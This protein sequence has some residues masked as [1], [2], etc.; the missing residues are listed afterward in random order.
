[1]SIANHLSKKQDK[2][3]QPAV[4]VI[5]AG[6]HARRI[7][8]PELINNSQIAH[9]KVVILDV[10]QSA[11]SIAQY[12][13]ERDYTERVDTYYLNPTECK[14]S[15]NDI[16]LSRKLLK[17]Y[18]FTAVIISTDPTHHV[19]YAKWA[20][21]HDLHILMDKPVSTRDG[22]VSN[23]RAFQLIEQDYRDL[24]DVYHES[25]SLFCL[26]TQRRYESGYNFVFEKLSEVANTFNMPVTSIQAFHSDG[27]W[28]F[29]DEIMH[30]TM[31]P[32]NTGYGKLSHSGFH[33]LDIAWQFLEHGTPKV[34]MPD[35]LV[36]YASAIYPNG[37][38][39]SIT[40]DDYRDY[41][42]KYTTLHNLEHYQKSMKNFG[43]IDIMANI[44]MKREGFAT[45]LIGVNLLHS[46]FSKRSWRVPATDLYK[47]NGRVKHQSYVIEQGPFQCIQ[48]HNYQAVDEHDTDTGDESYSV[49]GKNHFDIYVFR[50]SEMF[51]E[52]EPA[53]QVYSSADIDDMYASQSSKLSNELAKHVMINEFLQGCHDIRGGK[54]T[55]DTVTVRNSITTYDVPV[56][57]MAALYESL[58]SERLH[59]TPTIERSI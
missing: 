16:A 43:E 31:H 58:V 10:F 42:G 24:M 38:V 36:A 14:H 3:R 41:F 7:Y 4:L 51:G 37:Y 55:R 40:P 39:S 34:K 5:G 19:D 23:S 25:R 49:G 54:H 13:L 28:I 59:L 35:T 1:M 22:A 26:S 29:P 50:N 57:M 21:A 9:C 56:K 17:A 33:V 2:T 18:D 32:Y 27:V 20:L 11:Q 47:G 6:H 15:F 30:Q 8:I 53:L 44:T 48:I 12:L 45:A 52:N 46:S